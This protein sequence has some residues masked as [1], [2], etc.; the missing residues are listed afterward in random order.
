[1][2]SAPPAPTPAPPAGAIEGLKSLKSARVTDPL[3][4]QSFGTIRLYADPSITAPL[5]IAA[6]AAAATLASAA[7]P[8]AAPM[9][10][11]RA[12]KAVPGGKLGQTCENCST[13]SVS[14]FTG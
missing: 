10:L 13:Q 4:G 3:T 5:H 6:D 11:P 14:H 2:P 9:L 12:A 8:V 7:V 1:M